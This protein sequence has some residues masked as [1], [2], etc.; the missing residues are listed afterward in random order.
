MFKIKHFC[1]YESFSTRTVASQDRLQN[2]VIGCFLMSCE[3]LLVTI[4]VSG[5]GARLGLDFEGVAILGSCTFSKLKC[6]VFDCSEGMRTL[7]R[8]RLRWEDSFKM[9]LK[10]TERERYGLD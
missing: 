3:M 6:I 1:S 9:D 8:L 2:I 5:S 4:L 7:G 10:S